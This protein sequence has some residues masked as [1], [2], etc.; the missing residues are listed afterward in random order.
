MKKFDEFIHWRYVVELMTVLNSFLFQNSGCQL[1]IFATKSIHSV[2]NI[3]VFSGLDSCTSSAATWPLLETF[4]YGAL[5]I[6]E[7]PL[8]FKRGPETY[9]PHHI[10]VRCFIPKRP[11]M[12]SFNNPCWSKELRGFAVIIPYGNMRKIAIHSFESTSPSKDTWF[13]S[14][15]A[16]NQAFLYATCA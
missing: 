1:T 14:W 6:S 9:F 11:P 12:N 10:G 8:V 3:P 16:I 13:S 7:C 15:V 4:R 5:S 2:F